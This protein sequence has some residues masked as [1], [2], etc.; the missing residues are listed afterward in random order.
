MSFCPPHAKALL[1]E[2][3]LQLLR[4]QTRLSLILFTALPEAFLHL[5]KTTLELETNWI[6]WTFS[7]FF[8]TSGSKWDCE[9]YN[10]GNYLGA[11][12]LGSSSL[13]FF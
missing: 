4:N 2:V 11:V 6:L 13:G 3:T 9:G 8:L 5:W 10:R 7:F 12:V 1:P